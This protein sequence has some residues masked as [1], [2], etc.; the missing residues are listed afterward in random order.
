MTFTVNQEWDDPKVVGI[1]TLPP[2]TWS[3]PAESAES[4][5]ARITSRGHQFP[6]NALSCKDKVQ[7]LNGFWDFKLY[8]NPRS[9]ESNWFTQQETEFTQIPV[10]SNWEMVGHDIP[11]Y[12]N[13]VYPFD[14]SN[15]PHAPTEDN[16]VGCYRRKLSIPD[17][18]ECTDKRDR[19]IVHFSGVKSCIY[20]WV[21]GQ[22]VGFS[23]DSM[24]AV[25]FDITGNVK[26]GEDNVLAAQVIRWCDGSYLE[27][28][29]F[30]DLSGIQRDVLLYCVP[31]EQ[32]YLQD[33]QIDTFAD[34]T[35][36]IRGQLYCNSMPKDATL[37]V[38]LRDLGNE[39]TTL[40]TNSYLVDSLLQGQQ[41][42]EDEQT[43]PLREIVEKVQNIK[44]WTG[45]APHLYGVTIELIKND[46]LLDCRAW[47]VGFR[48][49]AINDQHQICVNDMPIMFRGVNRHE[50]NPWRGRYLTEKDMLEDIHLFLQHNV[51]TVRTCHYPNSPR[52]YELCDEYGIYVM[53]EVNIET[54]GMDLLG[55]WDRLSKDAD[56][57]DAY[58]DRTKRMVQRDRNFTSIV[59]WSLGNES[60]YGQNQEAQYDWIKSSDKSGRPVHYEGRPPDPTG[61]SVEAV[62]GTTHVQ[63]Y[64]AFDINSNMYFSPREVQ[65]TT[66]EDPNRPVV[67]CE[68]A[69]AM[70]NGTGNF[71][72]Y[73]E[74]WYNNPR[75]QGGWIWD[76][77]DQGIALEIRENNPGA[78]Y[79][80]PNPDI[81]H[82]IAKGNGCWL[83]GGDFGEQPH[84]ADF[85]IN[86]M[87][88]PD[89]V[90]HPGCH[91]MKHCYSPIA[92][93]LVQCDTTYTL[94]E[95]HNRFDFKT[96]LSQEYKIS[97]E[98]WDESSH[99]IISGYESLPSNLLPRQKQRLLLEHKETASF[100]RS[101]KW[102]APK[103]VFVNINIV[104][105]TAKEWAPE[106]SLIAGWQF[107]VPLY[108]PGGMP[109]PAK[110]TGIETIGEKEAVEIVDEK[111]QLILR[112]K[113]KIASAIFNKSSGKLTSYTVDGQ[114]LLVEG[115]SPNFWRA[116]TSNDEAGGNNSY[117][118][119]WRQAG[120]DNL[121]AQ[122][123]SVSK[124]THDSV[125]V[126]GKIPLAKPSG[127]IDYFMEYKLDAATSELYVSVEYSIKFEQDS[128][129][130]QALTF[131]RVGV[132]LKLPTSTSSQYRYAGL[133]P[134]E[135]YSDRKRSAFQ[136]IH[137]IDI[138]SDE[139]PYV[140]P[141]AYGN[142]EEVRWI[143]ITNEDG[144]QGI[145]ATATQRSLFS[146]SVHP[147]SQDNLTAAKH[148]DEVKVDN[149][150]H[151]YLDAA[152]SGVGGDDS[153]TRRIH[154]Q[155]LVEDSTYGLR[156]KLSK[157]T[158]K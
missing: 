107:E 85:C 30:W 52:W 87:V 113:D 127:T 143:E 154:K 40:F 41:Q 138:A 108:E 28:Q 60:G 109:S 39:H 80:L 1:N 100:L 61:Q 70:G 17:G 6:A 123:I 112:S 149:C 92:L 136:G 124:V 102:S 116:P 33:T 106:N 114:S 99:K 12:T 25:E 153:W 91:E 82:D 5:L 151:L 157:P 44:Q 14:L 9:V 27:D 147:Y 119:Y 132:S 122:D 68:F 150:V 152:H 158:H 103:Q 26:P 38:V 72:E 46:Q 125:R 88:A 137:V 128:N 144:S 21:N 23:K 20:L 120:L 75:T 56:W 96:D 110:F 53:D 47:R 4:G 83:Y 19:I 58:V 63:K 94:I 67:S 142:R 77:V 42:K 69:H 49:V 65:T 115:P 7:S 24:T 101:K 48:T 84:D 57:K 51:N 59:I 2:R 97:W 31:A 74:V 29:D 35:F 15:V 126:T 54:H 8:P 18:W 78:K 90:P 131:P 117:A 135:N 55:D 45:E 11:R 89:R 73:V 22:F 36:K 146:A 3:F 64:C 37:R 71:E 140:N 148:L 98:V 50:H 133:G 76:W 79:H 86:G 129:I 118:Y 134:F 104:S 93:K 62:N 145:S 130:F 141:Q 81:T 34:G 95:V 111:D 121:K 156:F 139:V 105:T 32:G 13:I 43:Y 155:Y 10:P 16:P 66:L